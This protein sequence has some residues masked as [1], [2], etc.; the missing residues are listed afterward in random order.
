MIKAE[1]YTPG[2]TKN[3][4]DFM[5]KRTLDSHGSFFLPYL[6]ERMSVLDSGCGPGTITLGIARRVSPAEVVGVDFGQSQIDRATASA[7]DQRVANVRFQV[8]DCYSLPFEDSSFYRVFSHALMEHLADP[9]RA[10]REMYRVLKPGGIIGLC[11]PDWGG[12]ILSPPSPKMSRAL[13]AYMSLQSKNGGDV[14]AGRKLGD[15]LVEAGFGNVRMA[16]RYECYPSLE[17]IGEYL[18]LQLECKGDVNSSQAFREWSRQESGL[19]AQAWVS[20]VA[21]KLVGKT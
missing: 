21:T 7:S 6:N 8:A 17:F 3:A 20:S 14:T 16:A 12:F 15:Y 11:S 2:H 13:D 5:A 18:A 4:S 10:L 1:S 19:F 9:V